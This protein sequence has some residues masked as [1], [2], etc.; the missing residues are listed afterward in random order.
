MKYE[1]K[2]KAR[3]GK[4]KIWGNWIYSFEWTQHSIHFRIPHLE[5]HLFFLFIE[6]SIS[7]QNL[8][9]NIWRSADAQSHIFISSTILPLLLAYSLDCEIF[10][11]ISKI[12]K[13]KILLV[14]EYYACYLLF[15]YNLKSMWKL[16]WE[17]LSFKVTVATNMHTWKWGMTG[18]MSSLYIHS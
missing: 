18:S 10:L 9:Y 16:C 15:S 3:Q 6:L 17:R 5:C 8:P 7:P 2:G 11:E 4:K 1:R 14:L 12:L 13:A